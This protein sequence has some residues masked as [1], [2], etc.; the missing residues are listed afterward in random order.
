MGGYRP[1]GLNP[2]SNSDSHLT[3][4]AA[5]YCKRGRFHRYR[6][7]YD[8]NP[9]S[10]VTSG[11]AFDLS[12]QARFFWACRE[13]P[14]ALAL[15][16]DHGVMSSGQILWACT[17]GIV[18]RLCICRRIASLNLTVAPAS[19]MCPEETHLFASWWN[20]SRWTVNFVSGL[21]F[22]LLDR[23]VQGVS[24]PRSRGLVEVVK[25]GTGFALEKVLTWKRLV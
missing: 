9:G 6:Y 3:K 8:R 20:R 25:W 7:I 14:L 11:E 10:S 17:V 1:L 13:K 15:A 19:G 12:V 16:L 2:I 23:P 18:R 21:S 4:R 24:K 22:G 5:S